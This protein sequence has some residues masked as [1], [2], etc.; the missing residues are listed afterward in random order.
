MDIYK[1]LRSLPLL[2]NYGKDKLWNYIENPK[3]RLVFMKECVDY[4]SKEV[5]RSIEEN[6][7]NKTYPSTQ[8]IKEEIEKYFGITKIDKIIYPCL[9]VL[10][11]ECEN[12]EEAIKASRIEE[13]KKFQNRF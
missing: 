5:L 13:I 7:K 9:K 2:K 6:N 12:I 8:I 11:Q 10:E 4:G 1:L 3:R